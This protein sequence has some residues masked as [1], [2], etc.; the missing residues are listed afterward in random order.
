[1]SRGML[2]RFILNGTV[3]S[4]FSAMLAIGSHSLEMTRESSSHSHGLD[5]IWSRLG[6][7]KNRLDISSGWPSWAESD[8]LASS[9]GWFAWLSIVL[10]FSCQLFGLMLRCLHGPTLVWEHRVGCMRCS[11]PRNGRNPYYVMPT[12]RSKVSSFLIEEQKTSY[13]KTRII[14][15]GEMHL[16]LFSLKTNKKKDFDRRENFLVWDPIKGQKLF[17]RVFGVFWVIPNYILHNSPKI[18]LIARELKIS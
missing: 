14:H 8:L 6:L 16:L 17:G 7:L 4:T 9:E 18:A 2:Y 1:M 3:P 10:N 12:I 11:F 5:V 13:Y 15:V